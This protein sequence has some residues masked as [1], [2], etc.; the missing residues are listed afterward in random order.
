MPETPDLNQAEE[1]LHE[2]SPE[3]AQFVVVAAGVSKG[4]LDVTGLDLDVAVIDLRY[5]P[6]NDITGRHYGALLV[7]GKEHGDGLIAD[8]TRIMG[9]LPTLTQQ[10]ADVTP[11]TTEENN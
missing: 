11:T 2:V 4:T 9:D 1:P 8:L 7:I 6:V 3:V 10:V 5:V